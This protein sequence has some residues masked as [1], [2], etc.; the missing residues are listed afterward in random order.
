MAKHYI[1]QTV[2]ENP[3]YMQADVRVPA[4]V[5]LVAGNVVVAE[6]LDTTLRENTRVYSPKKVADATKEDI[7]LI[8]NNGFEKLSDGRLPA[9]QP[10]YTQYEYTN[11]EVITAHRLLPETRYR[12]SIDA[13][14]DTV[15][16]GTVK[17]G[18]NLIPKNGQ[19]TLSYSAKGTAVTTKNYLT[20]E[21]ITYFQIGGQFG[22]EMVPCLIVRAKT[23]DATE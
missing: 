9:G 10:D 12:I 23:T 19:Y 20:V 7:A 11:G 5:T 4:A 13:C 16:V 14:D 3:A 8:L 1:G 2:S 22:S 17:V 6:E 21:A 18:D 15:V